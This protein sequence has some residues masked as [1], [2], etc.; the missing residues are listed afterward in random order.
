M[1]IVTEH[2]VHVLIIDISLSLFLSSY[3][4]LSEA[5]DQLVSTSEQ[6]HQTMG[7]PLSKNTAG[8]NEEDSQADLDQPPSQPTSPGNCM[9]IYM[10]LYREN[11][12]MKII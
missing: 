1:Y 5:V 10:Y 4:I 3:F 6:L 7:I 12:C 11:F 8:L 2:T 9:Y